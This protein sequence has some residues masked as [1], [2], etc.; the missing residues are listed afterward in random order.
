MVACWQDRRGEQMREGRSERAQVEKVTP[1]G[2]M[3]LL[4]L[5]KAPTL[6]Q[7]GSGKQS[8]SNSNRSYLQPFFCLSSA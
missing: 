5:T 6:S 1:P 8:F 4:N 2:I 7:C 3:G